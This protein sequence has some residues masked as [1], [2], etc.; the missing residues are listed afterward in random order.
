MKL[1]AG[2][3]QKLNKVLQIIFPVILFLYPLRHICYGVGWT[4]T[5][6]NYG[7]FMY[8]D[9]MDQMWLFGTYLGTA[10]GNL[11]T[12]LPL[13][14][15]MLGLN[16]YTGLLVSVLA[17]AGYLFFVKEVKLSPILT[18]IGEFIAVNLC[19]CP[20]ALLYNYLTYVFLGTGAVLLYLALMQGKHSSLCF[21]LAG[22]ALGINVFVRFANLTN[23]ALI[24]AVWAMGIIRR[25]KVSKVLRQTGLCI[26]GYVIGLGGCF[27]IISLKYGAMN[28][29]QGI[30]RLLS[31]PSEAS[32]YSILSMVLQMLRNYIQNLLWLGILAGFMI[33][34]TIVY[35]LLPK[36]WKWVKNIGY[37]G[38]VFCSFYVLWALQM[39]NMEYTTY[40]SMFQ[41]AVMLLTATLAAGLVVIFG[42]GFTEQEKLLCGISMIVVLITPLGSNNH[43]YLAMNNLFFIL[44]FTLG[45]LWRFVKW[46]PA[47]GRL[48]RF[49]VG[50]YPLKAMLA[51]IFFMIMLQT[52]LFGWK[53]VF[54]ESGGGENFNTTVENNAILKGMYMEPERAESISEISAYV[55]E[56]GL[57]GKEVILYG[58][59]PAMS[60]YL[61][62][63]FAISSWPDL[64]SY[65]ASVME[66]DLKDIEAEAAEGQRELPVIL[67]EK[68]SGSYVGHGLEGLKAIGC[69][70][71]EEAVFDKEPKVQL[72]KKMIEK[73]AYQVTFENDK[74]VLFQAGWEE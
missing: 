5:A 34:G 44:P 10:L 46:L 38:A 71:A 29:I 66:A 63:P 1:E 13:G 15:T 8:M 73:Y 36:A 23:M 12:K 17:V 42:R 53:F 54:L 24:V 19:W 60:F 28:Y 3:N 68:L 67:M 45:L 48:R 51:C 64:R 25:E 41:W 26:L 4:D 35:Q 22:I 2:K 32:D 58:Q 18:F 65:H 39:F 9:N 69:G 47:E 43:L 31:M 74:F 30:L 49:S 62:M 14:N 20:T 55:K 52:T 56:Q 70:E 21:V 61:E 16:L 33:L 57:Q 37:V 27:G 50:L 6:Y 7:N 59:I 72:L 11:F 40:M